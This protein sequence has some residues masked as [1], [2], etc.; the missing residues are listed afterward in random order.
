MPVV[1]T[2]GRSV[3]WLPNFLGWVDLFTHGAPQARFARG[4]L[5]S[6]HKLLER[7]RGYDVT[8]QLCRYV[9]VSL[10]YYFKWALYMTSRHS[11]VITSSGD[12]SF[13][14]LYFI[15]TSRE[16]HMSQMIIQVWRL[17]HHATAVSLRHQVSYVVTVSWRSY[18]YILLLLQMSLI[19]E[20]NSLFSS[21]W[22]VFCVSLFC[23]VSVGANI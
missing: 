1:R 11:C 22:D 20:S 16:P 23:A 8:P 18:S 13:L 2:D 14:Q 19:Y 6:L 17:W 3:T 12:L 4:A 10:Y 15:I 5:L 7:C 9:T 21:M